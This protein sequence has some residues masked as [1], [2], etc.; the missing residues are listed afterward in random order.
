M[1]EEKTIIQTAK[2][3]PV[4]VPDANGAASMTAEPAAEAE[5]SPKQRRKRR[6]KAEIEADAKKAA[7]KARH[8][9]KKAAKAA[10]KVAGKTVETVAKATKEAVEGG[11]QVAEKISKPRIPVPEIVLQYSGTEVGAAELTDAA[12][13][14]FS[15][16][17]KRVKIK[18][19]K[20]YVKPEDRAAYYVINGKYTGKV[21][22]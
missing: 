8:G 4:F 20:L 19:I 3:E 11:A 10:G 14:Q 6:T 16:A 21:E 15:S 7:A 22:F 9:A 17:R 2:E 1:D 5:A 13:A 18:D 12:I